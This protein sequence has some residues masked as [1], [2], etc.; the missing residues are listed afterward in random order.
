MFYILQAYQFIDA[1]VFL[2]INTTLFTYLIP[3]YKAG[4]LTKGTNG[5]KRIVFCNM[6]PRLMLL[7]FHL[8]GIE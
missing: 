2:Y 4:I 7:S 6:N 5:V 1:P 8:T 3:D